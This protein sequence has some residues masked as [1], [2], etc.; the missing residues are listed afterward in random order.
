[1]TNTDFRD[2]AVTIIYGVDTCEDTTR[3][4]ERFDAA[5]R[6]YRYVRLDEDTAARDRLH[7]ASYVSTPV[8]VTPG[9]TLAVEPSD[10]ILAELI[11][12]TARAR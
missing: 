3:A 1:M 12:E 4:R 11:A 2:P 6:A 5:G 10:E 9:G 8:V 7:A